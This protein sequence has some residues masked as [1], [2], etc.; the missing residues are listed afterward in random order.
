M[1]Y[2]SGMAADVL[3][4]SYLADS[5]ITENRL[6]F[7]LVWGLVLIGCAILLLGLSQPLVLLVI[8]AVTGGLMM[9]IYSILLI[10]LNRKTRP[11]PIRIGPGWIAALVW[12][13]L[14]FGLLSAL[15]F[16][17]QWQRLFG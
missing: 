12:S 11:D 2:T 5:A 7:G 10:V 13:T 17:Q 9:F 15:T 1:D 3:K 8:W 16:G 14:L 4:T 6:S